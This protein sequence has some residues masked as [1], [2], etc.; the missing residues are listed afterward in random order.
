[1]AGILTSAL[2]AIGLRQPAGAIDEC[3]VCHRGVRERDARM[4]LPG[5]GYVHR[6]CSTYRMRQREQ[7]RRRVRR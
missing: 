5:G 2:S 3:A 6:G 4:R 7:L 1:M